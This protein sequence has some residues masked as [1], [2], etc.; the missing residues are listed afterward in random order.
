VAGRRVLIKSI[1]LTEDE[2]AEL[3]EYL[4]A[5]GEVEAVTLRRA[6]MRGLRE[7]R[8]SHA[9][10]QYVEDRDSERAAQIAGLPRAE[11]LHL[12]AQKGISV[13]DEPSTLDVELHALA[14]QFDDSRLDAAANE[15]TGTTGKR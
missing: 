11:F 4:E 14:R 6:A 8:V 13:L 3:R 9:I 15:L 7:M 2:A 10:Q 5:T 1:R 12:L